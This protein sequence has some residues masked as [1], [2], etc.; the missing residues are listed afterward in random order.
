MAELRTGTQKSLSFI[1]PFRSGFLGTGSQNRLVWEPYASLSPLNIFPS[2][3]SSSVGPLFF[4]GRVPAK[5][6][7]EVCSLSP[8]QTIPAAVLCACHTPPKKTPFRIFRISEKGLGVHQCWDG[9]HT[10]T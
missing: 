5:Q 8:T 3:T 6:R 10:Y 9:R 1:R 4:P 2:P 7:C